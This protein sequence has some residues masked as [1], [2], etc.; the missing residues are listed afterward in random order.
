MQNQ[1]LIDQFNKNSAEIVKVH[2]QEWKSQTYF[3][4]R[5]WYLDNP[6]EN[7]SEQATKKGLTLNVELLPRLIKAL[8]KAEKALEKGQDEVKGRDEIENG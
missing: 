4:V 3:D 8:Q 2:V 1:K 7:G 6:A 5:V